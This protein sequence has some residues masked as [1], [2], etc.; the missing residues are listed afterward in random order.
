MFLNIT[1][2]ERGEVMGGR[3]DFIFALRQRELAKKFVK[4]LDRLLV[5]RGD[6]CLRDRRINHIDG[7]SHVEMREV[8]YFDVLN[9]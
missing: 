4:D 9:Y 6:L 8:L 3:L 1:I 5:L 7:R 2:D